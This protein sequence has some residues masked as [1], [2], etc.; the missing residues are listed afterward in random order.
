[1]IGSRWRGFLKN[2]PRWRWFLERRP[3]RG[4]PWIGIENADIRFDLAKRD[5]MLRKCGLDFAKGEES[6]TARSFISGAVAGAS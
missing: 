6:C 2:G 4:F 5:Q 1:M 3:P